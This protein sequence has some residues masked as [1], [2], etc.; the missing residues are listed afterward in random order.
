[1]VKQLEVSF[2]RSFFATSNR[3]GE[4]LRMWKGRFQPPRR[5]SSGNYWVVLLHKE[6]RT[7]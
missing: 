5:E 7:L 4:M 1:M 6:L 3:N 2:A